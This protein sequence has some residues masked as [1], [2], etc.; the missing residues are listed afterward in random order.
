[1]KTSKTGKAECGLLARPP[2]P[3]RVTLLLQSFFW[4]TKMNQIISS[5]KKTMTSQEIADLVGSRHDSVKRTIERLVEKSV[6]HIP[7]TVEKPTGGRPVEEY[8]FSGEKGKRD[9]LVVVAQLSPEFTG[10]LVDRWKELESQQNITLPQSFA[11]ALRLAADQQEQIEQQKELLAIAAPKAEFVDKYVDST[12]LKGFRQT[13]KLLSAN[14][15]R[16]RDFLLDK[17]I[18]YRLGG[19]WQAYQQH[20][21]AGR[22]QVK[23]GS[24]EGG[25][26]FNQ[27]K[28][29]AKGVNWIAGLWAQH[30]LRVEA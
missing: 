19:E 15:A 11:E 22:F 7:P 13:A 27:T 1:M 25:H 28:F 20:I 29:T 4:L 24:S 21:D 3:S 26:A 14:E 8:V 5:T 30:N 6:I 17:K 18:M 12:G 23:T 10:A 9:S 16:F 2:T